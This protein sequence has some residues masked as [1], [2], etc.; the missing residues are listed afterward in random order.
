MGQ[1]VA[2][3][4]FSADSASER[5]V[6]LSL[7]GPLFLWVLCLR[8]LDVALPVRLLKLAHKPPQTPDS[9]QSHRIVNRSPHP[10]DRPVATKPDRPSRRS[11]FGKFLLKLLIPPGHPKSHIHPRPRFVLDRTHIIPAARINRVIK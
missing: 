3:P 7:R 10:P 4:H 2:S 9:L 1:G 6:R 8:S 11:L 5:Q